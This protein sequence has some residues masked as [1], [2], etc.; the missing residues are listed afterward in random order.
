MLTWITRS[1]FL[2]NPPK[3]VKVIIIFSWDLDRIFTT[4]HYAF[5]NVNKTTY[6]ILHL[7]AYD[8]F[9][10]ESRSWSTLLQTEGNKKEEVLIN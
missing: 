7:N 5:F 2:E 1:Y 3:M 8:S 4:S 9:E 10:I 6:R